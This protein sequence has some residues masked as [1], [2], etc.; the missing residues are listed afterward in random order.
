MQAPLDNKE[1]V[2]VPLFEDEVL[3]AAPLGSP[4]AGQKNP[5]LKLLRNE[6]FITLG[7]GFVTPDSFRHAFSRP[8]LCRRR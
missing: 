5:D 2:A 6:K 7:E 1:L 4:Y 3:L 8:G